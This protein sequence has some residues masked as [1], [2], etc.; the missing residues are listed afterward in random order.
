MNI[1]R[2]LIWKWKLEDFGFSRSRE[3]KGRLRRQAKK[4][5]MREYITDNEKE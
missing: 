5:S 3:T 2:Y 1:N 4:R